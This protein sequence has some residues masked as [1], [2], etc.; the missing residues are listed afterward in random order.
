MV[1]KKTTKGLKNKKTKQ[2]F[3][4]CIN[5]CNVHFFKWK[6]GVWMKHNLAISFSLELHHRWL[7]IQVYYGLSHPKLMDYNT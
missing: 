2:R 5:I 7:Q 3:K 4:K 1:F 6:N